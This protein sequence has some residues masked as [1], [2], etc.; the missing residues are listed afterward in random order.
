MSMRNMYTS[1]I[2]RP[3]P[4]LARRRRRRHR[5]VFQGGLGR[6]SQ[7][8]A[9]NPVAH[10]QGWRGFETDSGHV[11]LHI[12]DDVRSIVRQQAL[13]VVIEGS[14]RRI[15]PQIAFVRDMGTTPE[16]E[17]MF[18]EALIAWR[19][20]GDATAAISH[21]DRALETH[22][23]NIENLPHDADYFGKL[24]PAFLEPT[25]SCAPI[26][27][28]SLLARAPML[29]EGGDEV[30]LAFSAE[31]GTRPDLPTRYTFEGELRQKRPD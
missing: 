9:H 28:L 4:G 3:R 8:A 14:R 13:G 6:G 1:V 12:A 5:K 24:N 21:L 17:M 20:G 26:F 29:V 22:M 19:R 2:R 7:I 23:S 30:S 11:V 10:Q 15:E 31:L 27:G 18:S 25:A 16:P